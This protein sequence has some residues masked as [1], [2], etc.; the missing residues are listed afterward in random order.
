MEVY[1]C[2]LSLSAGSA[3]LQEVPAADMRIRCAAL[4]RQYDAPAVRQAPAVFR[5]ASW[6]I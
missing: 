5:A 6:R 3:L 1:R 4:Q 2:T